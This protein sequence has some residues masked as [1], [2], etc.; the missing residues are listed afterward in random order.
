MAEYQQ[1]RPNDWEAYSSISVP[2]NGGLAT[3]VSGLLNTRRVCVSYTVGHM[4]FKIDHQVAD[5]RALAAEL[6]AAADAVETAQ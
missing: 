3:I 6:I 4:V 1:Q 2:P 5:A